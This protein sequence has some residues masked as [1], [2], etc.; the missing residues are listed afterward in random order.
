MPGVESPHV[1][2]IQRHA[3]DLIVLY[4][5]VVSPVENG[6]VGQVMDEIVSDPTPNGFESVLPQLD[7]GCVG[8]LH[9]PDTV[10]VVVQDLVAG[11]R[12][13]QAVASSYVDATLARDGG[14]R[15]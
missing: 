7:R 15:N 2:R 4:E 5:V 9:L 1:S 14:Y 13:G 3:P 10:D 6:R 12:Q 11:R 8:R